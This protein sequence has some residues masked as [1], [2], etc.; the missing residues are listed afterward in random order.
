[1]HHM[2]LWTTWCIRI[3]FKM[4]EQDH[5]ILSCSISHEEFKVL[6][7]STQACYENFEGLVGIR[8]V[9][10]SWRSTIMENFNGDQILGRQNT[11]LWGNR[12]MP[13][14]IDIARQLCLDHCWPIIS[15][16]WSIMSQKEPLVIPPMS[17]IFSR[18]LKLIS[19]VATGGSKAKT[20][21]FLCELMTTTVPSGAGPNF[22]WLNII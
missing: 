8:K 11:A 3:S 12:W 21:F 5:C 1:M 19:V 10:R 13:Q 14:T 6:R 17:M 4:S 22:S 16:R 15:H 2:L 20:R 9:L 18:K 7:N